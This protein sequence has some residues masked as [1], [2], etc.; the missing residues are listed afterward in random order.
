MPTDQ[1]TVNVK[2][3][4]IKSKYAAQKT[5][6]WRCKESESGI[7]LH[8]VSPSRSKLCVLTD[9]QILQ[10]VDYGKAISRQS[11]QDIEWAV[12]E[13]KIYILQARPITAIAGQL[14]W[15]VPKPGAWERDDHVCKPLSK[16]GAELLLP[17]WDAGVRLL[18]QRGGLILSHADFAIMN[19]FMYYCIRPLGKPDELPEV[20]GAGSGAGH[21][22]AWSVEAAS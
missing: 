17:A 10:L 15:T 1:Y 11:P 3:R 6:E 4:T 14:D 12:A 22:G 5:H 19:G 20:L 7:E 9:E 18:A 2:N 21:G 16:L 8:E 13:G